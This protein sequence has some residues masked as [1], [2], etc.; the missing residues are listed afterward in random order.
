MQ[1][2][3]SRRKILV[4]RVVVTVI[5]SVRTIS[6]LYNKSGTSTN[7]LARQAADASLFQLQLR[8]NVSGT[9]R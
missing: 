1:A 3:L 6:F 2:N 8:D 5:R 7:S 4:I 9:K